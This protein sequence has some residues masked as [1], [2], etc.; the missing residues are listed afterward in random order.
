MGRYYDSPRASYS[1][2]DYRIPTQVAAIEAIQQLTPSDK[3]TIDEMRRW[4]LQEKR[5]QAWDTPINSSEAIYAFLN[6][7]SQVL[8]PQTKTELAIDGKPLETSKATAGIGYVKTSMPIEG[9][10]TFTAKKTSTGTSW[11]AVYA[12]FMQDTKDIQDQS[13]ELSVKREVL[14]PGNAAANATHDGP[15]AKLSVGQ[16]IKVRITITAQRDLDFVEVIDRRAACMEPLNQLSGYHYGYYCAPKDNATHY[17]F[18]CL[19]KGKHV[20]ETEYYIDRTGQ[21]ETGTCTAQ[22]AYAPEFR[23]TTHSQTLIIEE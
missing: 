2:R 10:Q 14:M 21:Y 11:G 22:C 9:Q 18:D 19:R 6:K 15:N 4:L 23:G 7:N 16:R 1:W 20:I 3:K 12:Q 5:A 8:Q 17:Y 13:S